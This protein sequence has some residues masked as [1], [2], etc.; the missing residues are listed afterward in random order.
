MFLL[1]GATY[2][3]NLISDPIKFISSTAYHSDL[4]YAAFKSAFQILS[5]SDNYTKSLPVA[6]F[7]CQGSLQTLSES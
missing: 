3:V 7:F 4:E 2:L 1:S 6:S 5:F